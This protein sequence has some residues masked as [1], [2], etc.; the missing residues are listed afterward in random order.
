LQ[1]L[2]NLAKA[3]RRVDLLYKQATDNPKYVPLMEEKMDKQWAGT[4]IEKIRQAINDG[5]LPKDCSNSL[6]ELDHLS[7]IGKIKAFKAK[8]KTLISSATRH[9]MRTEAEKMEI[10]ERWNAHRIEQAGETAKVKA[11]RAAI[12]KKPITSFS[13][14]KRIMK[15]FYKQFPEEFNYVDVDFIS[16]NEKPNGFSYTSGYSQ[17]DKVIA[18]NSHKTITGQ[19]GAAIKLLRVFENIRLKNELTKADLKS[20]NTVVHELLHQKASKHIDLKPHYRGDYKRTAMETM[21]ELASR[22]T[23]IT[24]LRRIGANTKNVPLLLDGNGYKDWVDR[25]LSFINESG[26]N[27]TTVGKE[28]AS[29][30]TTK[31]YDTMDFELYNFFKVHAKKNFLQTLNEVLAAFESGKGWDNLLAKRFH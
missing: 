26:Y 10:Q 18:F 3:S 27:P 24:F 7:T 14:V 21:N 6:D 28:F 20:I 22:S 11:V 30:L 17:H 19:E 9:A 2:S 15:E 16:F 8:C 4:Q 31:A 1:H 12:E 23:A 13:D 25:L 29:I 5:Y